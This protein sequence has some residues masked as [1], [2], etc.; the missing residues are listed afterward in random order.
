MIT[1]IPEVSGTHDHRDP[2]ETRRIKAAWVVF[3][4][5]VLDTAGR[6]GTFVRYRCCGHNRRRDGKG[7]ARKKEWGSLPCLV[8]LLADLHLPKLDPAATALKCHV[9]PTTLVLRSRHPGGPGVHIREFGLVG[10]QDRLAIEPDRGSGAGAL[11]LDRVPLG[12]RPPRVGSWAVVPIILQSSL[13]AWASALSR[14]MSGQPGPMPTGGVPVYPL[15]RVDL[16]RVGPASGL[17]Q[18]DIGHLPPP[19]P[20]HWSGPNAMA[21]SRRSPARR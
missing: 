1:V 3:F 13:N 21:S 7:D 19:A 4:R 20:P 15:R 9:T 6:M 10:F 16:I 18:A 17:N 8:S 2:R 5:A 12:S 11:N 14:A